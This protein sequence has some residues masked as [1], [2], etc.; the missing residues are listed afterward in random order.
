M[1]FGMQDIKSKYWQKCQPSSGAGMSP[2]SY[3]QSNTVYILLIN[4]LKMEVIKSIRRLCLK[5]IH[6]QPSFSL[7]S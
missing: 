4:I 6:L 3:R 5:S 7:K 1:G 2:V